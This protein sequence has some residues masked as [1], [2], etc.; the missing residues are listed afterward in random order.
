MKI[1]IV[2]IRSY[3]FEALNL[4]TQVRHG[5]KI[6]PAEFEVDVLDKENPKCGNCRIIIR[7]LYSNGGRSKY[8]YECGAKLKWPADN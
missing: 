3:D 4:L 6:L 8:C 5:V 1:E 7:N 2:P